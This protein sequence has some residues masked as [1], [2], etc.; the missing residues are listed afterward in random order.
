[1]RKKIIAGNWK[2]NMT[3]SEAVKLCAVLKDLVVN[4]D[5]DVV[6]C[7]PAIDIVPVAE[8]IKGTNVNLG[9]QNF[10]IED[11]GAFTGEIS[12][13]MLKECGVKYV[14][15]GHSER[16]TYDN[17]TTEKCNLKMKALLVANIVPLYC[18]GESLETYE[19]GETKAFVGEQIVK[20]FEGVSADDAKKV[21]V[22]YEP[23][24]AIGTGKN[25][26]S[27]I[28][29]DICA[30]IRKRLKKLY[31]A[32]VA[33]KIRVLYGGSVKPNNIKEYLS[34]PDVDGALVGGASLKYE[35]YKEL[36]ENIL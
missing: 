25:A 17:E 5:V 20:G 4:D 35:S 31:G 12:A 36:L 9:A 23:I 16:R 11:S 3:P 32:K 6:Y 18:C 21:V 26:S 29:E 14:I 15:I 28:A 33:N 27:E 2:M 24:W 22:A 34:Q 10:Y 1:M 7:V 30:F 13:P 19:A 8:A